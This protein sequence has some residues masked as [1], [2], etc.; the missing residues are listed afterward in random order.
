MKSFRLFA[1]GSVELRIN[2]KLIKYESKRIKG[3]F[4][5]QT[6]VL[7][8]TSSFLLQNLKL[9]KA[10]LHLLH[11]IVKWTLEHF[12]LINNSVKSIFT[13]V[14]ILSETVRS[15]SRLTEKIHTVKHIFKSIWSGIPYQ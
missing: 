10:F 8:A 1:D 12:H 15:N 11:S 3:C 4:N 6:F 14:D 13:L 5:A 7:L 2:S 9:T